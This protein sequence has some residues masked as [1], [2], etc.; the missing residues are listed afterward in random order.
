MARTST[1]TTPPPPTT[2]RCDDGLNIGSDDDDLNIGSR[3]AQ[4]RWQ[5]RSETGMPGD[6]WILSLLLAGLWI[7]SL[8]LAGA[9]ILS[10]LLAGGMQIWLAAP[11]RR[12]L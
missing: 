8:L 11:S 4:H 9:L 6:A 1:V 5:H 7:L 12:S 10:I 3:R 2:P